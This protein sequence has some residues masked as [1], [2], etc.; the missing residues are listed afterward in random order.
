VPK[1]EEVYCPECQA[2]FTPAHDEPRHEVYCEDCGS[3]G[4]W[5][6]TECGELVDDVWAKVWEVQ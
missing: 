3:H 4:A 6:C 2:W 1:T 5:K